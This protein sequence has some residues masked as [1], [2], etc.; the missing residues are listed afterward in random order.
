MDSKK[1]SFGFNKLSKKTNIIPSTSRVKETKVELI[2]CLEEQS[3]KIK[4]AV[5]EI[6]EPLVIP[7]KDNERSLLDRIRE[8]K[9]KNRVVKADT[10][11]TRSDSE[12]TPDELAARELLK[13]AKNR[14]INGDSDNANKV[15]ILPIKEQQL[16]LE[17]E[18]QPTLEDYE[19]IP[20]ADFGLALLRGMGWKEGMPIGKKVSKSA[21]LPEPELRPKGLGLGASKMIQSEKSNNKQLDKEGN[22]LILVKGAYAKIIAGAQKG[23]YCQVQGFDEDGGRVIIKVHPKS[24]II[25]INEIM[26]MPV[27]KEEFSKGSKVLNN[28]KFEEFKEISDRKLKQERQDS[29]VEVNIK[30]SSSD[31]R[32]YKSSSKTNK[33]EDRG[34]IKGEASSSDEE[35]DTKEEHYKKSKKSRYKRRSS[36]SSDSEYTSSKKSHRNKSNYKDRGRSSDRHKKSSSYKSKTRQSSISDSDSDHKRNRR[37]MKSSRYRRGDSSEEDSRRQSRRK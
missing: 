17:G 20:I 14:L 22:E 8:A 19:S 33:Y 4:G 26:L 1:I 28:A 36:S 3:I 25:N 7:M 34:H 32:V 29:K 2:E 10:E 37:K 30:K 5:E 6:K 16:T 21:V 31:H 23:N 27:T 13:E 9:G 24:E 35:K 11:D 18:K 15:S 12:L